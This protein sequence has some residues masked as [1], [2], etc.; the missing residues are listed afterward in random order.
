V[1]YFKAKMHQIR[2]R[3]KRGE[4]GKSTSKHTFSTKIST[5]PL[6]CTRL[7][8]AANR[9]MRSTKLCMLLFVEAHQFDRVNAML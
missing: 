6:A 5:S 2:S 1:S 7:Q 4:D 9:G 8:E 3:L